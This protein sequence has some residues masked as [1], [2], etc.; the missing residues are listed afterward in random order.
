VKGIR[1]APDTSVNW[2]AY[3]AYLAPFEPRRLAVVAC[4]AGQYLPM[5]RIF[6]GLPK[7]RRI[8][9]TPVLAN[10]VLGT[11]MMLLLPYLLEH[12]IPERDMLRY[13]QVGLALDGRELWE[14]RRV[15]WQRTKKDVFTPIAHELLRRASSELIAWLTGKRR[16]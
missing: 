4:L 10:R 8:Y 3:A 12:V 11:V 1:I 13:L 15:D 5:G 16:A 7:V 9:A 2:S 14:W 6:A